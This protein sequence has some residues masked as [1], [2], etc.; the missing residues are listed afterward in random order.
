MRINLKIA[1]VLFSVALSLVAGAAFAIPYQVGEYKIDVSVRNSAMNLIKA[2]VSFWRIDGTRLS[3]EARATGYINSSTVL[4]L[5]PNQT[6]YKIDIVLADSQ[7]RLTAIDHNQRPLPSVFIRTDQYGFP[8]DKYGITA[9]IPKKMWANPGN[10]TV[11]IV[12]SFWGIPL[13]K[14]C[15]ISEEAEFYAVRMTITR[16]ALAWSSELMIVFRTVDRLEADAASSY[17]AKINAA[18]KQ[19]ENFEICPTAIATLVADFFTQDEL[20]E[21]TE[22]LPDV[23]KELFVQRAQFNQLYSSSR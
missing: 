6:V 18:T 14:S 7:H 19:K 15:E 20:L 17:L 1:I 5:L 23:L 10:R 2:K 22:S 21:V 11:T 8:S 3:V 9:Y 4:T 12:D 13:M 16:K